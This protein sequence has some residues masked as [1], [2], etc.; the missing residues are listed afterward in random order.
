MVDD[1]SRD[2]TAERLAALEAEM[3]RAC[4]W[5]DTRRIGAT[6]PALRSGFAAA[7]GDLIFYP[8][9]TTNSTSPSWP[10]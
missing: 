9:P 10:A 8:I 4:A 1:G 7:E 6:A 5:S 3:A 2:A